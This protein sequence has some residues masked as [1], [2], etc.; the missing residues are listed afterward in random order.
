[1]S[2]D[3]TSIKIGKA[4]RDRLK[5]HKMG[6]ETYGQLINKMIDQYDPQGVAK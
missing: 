5:T 4:T 6:G 3:L 2:R 1:M